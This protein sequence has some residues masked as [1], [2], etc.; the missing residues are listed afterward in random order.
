MA[1][2]IFEF[3]LGRSMIGLA[4]SRAGLRGPRRFSVDPLYRWFQPLER[5]GVFIS[6]F[7]A[8]GHLH[9]FRKR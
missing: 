4:A 7:H 9:G 2:S 5:T 1:F 3:A 8:Q 6:G